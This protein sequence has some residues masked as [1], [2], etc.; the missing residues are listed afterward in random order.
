MTVKFDNVMMSNGFKINKCDKCVYVKNIDKGY[1]IVCLYVDDIL[2]IGSDIGIINAT[3][4]ILNKQ[5]DMK[6]MGIADVILGIKV[7]RI[8]EG[9][10]LSQVHYIEKILGKFSKDDQH[11]A[12]THVDMTIHLAKNVGEGMSQIEY[13][14][15]I[16]GLMYVMNCTR[17]DITYDVSKLSRYTS[18]SGVDHWKAIIRVLKYLRYT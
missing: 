1:V 7:T 2:I 9:Y 4:K 3:K 6:D 15:I 10:N 16:G 5:F 18:N 14:R 8:S 13:T 12:K 11:I 17:P